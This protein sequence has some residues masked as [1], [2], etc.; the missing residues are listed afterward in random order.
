M[1][2]RLT[3][4]SKSKVKNV[5]MIVLGIVVSRSNYYNVPIFRIFI[6]KIASIHYCFEF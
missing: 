5:L 2:V 4:R 3:A 6:V 1:D